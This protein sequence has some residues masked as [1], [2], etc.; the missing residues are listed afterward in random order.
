M[1][2]LPLLLLGAAVA[3]P[4]AAQQRA[5]SVTVRAENPLS[6]ER[7]HETLAF[8]WADLAGRIPGL[9]ADRVRAVDPATGA[10]ILTQTLD[11]DGDNRPDSLLVLAAFWPKEAKLLRIEAAAPTQPAKPRVHAKYVPDRDDV[12]W[13]SERIAF[14]TYGQGLWKLEPETR[15]SGVDVWVKSTRNL[16]LDKWYAAGHDSYHVDK[17]EGADFYQVGLS[18]GMGGTAIYRDGQLF[19]ALNFRRQRVVA[20][21]PIRAIL[22]MEYEPWDA[23][24]VQV[25]ETKRI[26]ID[27]G[28][29]LF[30][31]TSVFRYD[32]GQ[33]LT[34]ATGTV[35]RPQ[36]VGTLAQDSA[37]A[38]MGTW[39]PIER[40]AHG[41]GQLGSVVMVPRSAAREMKQAANHY[42]VTAPVRSGVPVV[43]Y[44]GAGWTDSGDYP[45]PE[46]WWA[47]VAD[48]ADR[49]EHPVR[50]TVQPAAR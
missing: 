32:G 11:V 23:G 47:Y 19:R 15:S 41:H 46:T 30:R 8:A 36:L 49:M 33:E 45:H 42:L 29:N 34:Y 50:L 27:A 26:Q 48:F 18:M 25:S 17:G 9:A 28:E 38:W 7:P 40:A 24:G 21:G 16:V 37:W 1:K 6:V 4:A 35:M 5:A 20:D 44:A 2:K 10:E 14:R 22:E 31:S 13:E 39:G 12:A 43:H 3:A